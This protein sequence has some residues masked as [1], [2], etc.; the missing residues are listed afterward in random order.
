MDKYQLSYGFRWSPGI[1]IEFCPNDDVSSTPPDK[2]SV[3]ASPGAGTRIKAA[4]DE[5]RHN[6]LIFY[7]VAPFQLSAVARRTILGFEA[8]C[9][10]YAP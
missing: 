6:V 2:G 9:D 3:Y 8:L 1:K 7:E 5:V 10:L 4:N